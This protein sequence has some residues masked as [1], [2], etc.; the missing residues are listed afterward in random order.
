LGH[1]GEAVYLLMDIGDLPSTPVDPQT[2]GAVEEH[3]DWFL[4]VTTQAIRAVV[5]LDGKYGL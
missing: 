3:I 2:Q 4:T 1:I 5:G